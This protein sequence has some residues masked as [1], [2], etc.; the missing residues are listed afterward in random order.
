MQTTVGMGR[1]CR[2]RTRISR[3]TSELRFSG[4]CLGLAQARSADCLERFRVLGYAR[5]LPQGPPGRS[6][7]RVARQET[8]R[9]RHEP[10]DVEGSERCRPV[11]YLTGSGSNLCSRN[12]YHWTAMFNGFSVVERR[13]ISFVISA[14][15]SRSIDAKRRTSG[16]RR[17]AISSIL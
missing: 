2:K 12:A 3:R 13:L 17:R 11:G 1:E 15:G 16:N 4:A 7:G 8:R 9:L 6:F 5:G 10:F 14:V